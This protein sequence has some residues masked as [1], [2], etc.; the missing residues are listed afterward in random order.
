[1]L[2]FPRLLFA[3]YIRTAQFLN[4]DCFYLKGNCLTKNMSPEIK[5]SRDKDGF[6]KCKECPR[7]F[8]T[9]LAFENHSNNQKLSYMAKLIS[10]MPKIMAPI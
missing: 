1:M 10:I 4:L 7:R 6:L 5:D 8:L 2:N 3:Q 9:K